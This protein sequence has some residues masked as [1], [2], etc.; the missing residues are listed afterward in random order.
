M[1]VGLAGVHQRT[2][3]GAGSLHSP[4]LRKPEQN[5]FYASIFVET[6]ERFENTSYRLIITASNNDEIVLRSTSY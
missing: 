2:L 1:H 4:N 5:G 3:Y 6:A